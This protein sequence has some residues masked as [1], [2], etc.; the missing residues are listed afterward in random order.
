MTSESWGLAGER[1]YAAQTLRA[2]ASPLWQYRQ[3]PDGEAQPRIQTKRIRLAPEST[4][5]RGTGT[6]AGPFRGRC[7]SAYSRM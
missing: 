7:E 4:I 5:K 1:L 3:T 6:L 2:Q